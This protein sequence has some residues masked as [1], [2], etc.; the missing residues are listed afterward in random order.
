MPICNAK[1]IFVTRAISFLWEMGK[2]CTQ[3]I[4]KKWEISPQIMRGANFHSGL[5]VIKNFGRGRQM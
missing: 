5:F 4:E 1:S 2:S 3:R